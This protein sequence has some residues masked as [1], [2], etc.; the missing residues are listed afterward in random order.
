MSDS[1]LRDRVTVLLEEFVKNK[2]INP[3]YSLLCCRMIAEAILM[4]KHKEKVE[5]GEI[6]NII[7]I[8]DIN[9]KSFGFTKDFDALQMSSFDFINKSTSIFL[10]FNY[11]EPVMPDNLIDRVFDELQYLLHTTINYQIINNKE[12]KQDST[13]TVENI[14][15]EGWKE[16]L[17][18]ELENYDKRILVKDELK[19]HLVNF[20]KGVASA[21]KPKTSNAYQYVKGIEKLLKLSEKQLLAK[22]KNLIKSILII[23]F[24]KYGGSDYNRKKDS[25]SGSELRDAMVDA[26][27]LC[28]PMSIKGKLLTTGS[29]LKL[30]DNWNFL[31]M[32][33]N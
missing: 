31:K 12:E 25:I 28:G 32:V 7:T 2:D 26:N 19:K 10:H 14:K 21:K 18:I 22:E 29:K 5:D 4:L 15:T 20:K 30:K 8:G 24:Q 16:S 9:S 33:L 23:F 3:R 27:C 11:V 6:K 13:E 1:S 17:E